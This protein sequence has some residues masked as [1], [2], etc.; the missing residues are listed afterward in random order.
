MTQIV[1]KLIQSEE[2]EEYIIDSIENVLSSLLK[3]GESSEDQPKALSQKAQVIRQALSSMVADVLQT[4][5]LP[6]ELRVKA[7]EKV[8]FKTSQADRNRLFDHI[9]EKIDNVEKKQAI[10]NERLDKQLRRFEKRAEMIG[11]QAETQREQSILAQNMC[12]KV[13]SDMQAQTI[14]IR[15]WYEEFMA[16]VSMQSKNLIEEIDRLRARVVTTET[17]DINFQQKLGELFTTS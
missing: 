5:D 12:H 8:L 16:K 11:L 14:R 15:D 3:T 4:E 13:T 9:Y 10:E 17:A 2:Y 6:I 1:E 7:L